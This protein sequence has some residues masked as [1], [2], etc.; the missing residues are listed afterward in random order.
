MCWLGGYVKLL[1]QIAPVDSVAGMQTQQLCA[2]LC[3]STRGS[4]GSDAVPWRGAWGVGVAGLTTREAR[5]CGVASWPLP[6]G[7]GRTGSQAPAISH[8]ALPHWGSKTENL[9]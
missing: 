9:Y 7:R 5:T 8:R 3:A 1:R 6:A 4:V 2:S